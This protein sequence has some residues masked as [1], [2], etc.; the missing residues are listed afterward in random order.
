MNK[1]REYL[2]YYAPLVVW[3]T[4]IFVA[5]SSTGSMSNT[6]RFVRPVLEFL[7]PSADEAMLAAIHG[8][9]R[10]T[11]HFSGYAVLG[12]LAARAFHQTAIEPLRENRSLAALGLVVAVAAIDETNQ[13]RLASRTGSIYDVLLDAAGGLT[14]IL[15]FGFFIKRTFRQKS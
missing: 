6:S 8:Y 4:I 15:V 5:S 1:R 2:W 11:G 13:S 12:F 3:I 7:F 9:L 10:K 14:A